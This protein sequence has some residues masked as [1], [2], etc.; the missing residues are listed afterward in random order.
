MLEKREV[1]VDVTLYSEGGGEAQGSM[2][3]SKQFTN[4]LKY[5]RGKRIWSPKGANLALCFMFPSKNRY[6]LAMRR[7]KLGLRSS[8]PKT[9]FYS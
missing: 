1:L 3:Y 6:V 7:K 4:P 2:L 5:F 8:T 9:L